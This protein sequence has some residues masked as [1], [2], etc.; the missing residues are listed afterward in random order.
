M[1][2]K[3]E[4]FLKNIGPRTLTLDEAREL[5]IL[6]LKAG[7]TAGIMPSDKKDASGNT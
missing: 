5:H 1:K 7:D 3:I 4:E 6:R 2:D